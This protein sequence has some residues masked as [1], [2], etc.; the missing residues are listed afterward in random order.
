MLVLHPRTLI[1]IAAAPGWAVSVTVG[2]SVKPVGVFDC[3]NA[4]NGVTEIMGVDVAT[5][6]VDE[7]MPIT[8]GVAVNTDGVCVY[9]MNGVGGV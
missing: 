8:T 6:G 1:E 2:V 4:G 7:F 3:V 9:G 5:D